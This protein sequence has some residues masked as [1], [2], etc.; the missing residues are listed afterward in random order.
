M[1]TK[2]FRRHLALVGATV[3]TAVGAVAC[4]SDG[5]GDGGS[6]GSVTWYTPMPEEPARRLAEAF[7]RESGIEVKVLRQSAGELLARLKAEAGNPAADVIGLASGDTGPLAEENLIRSYESETAAEID[8]RFVDPDGYWH[9]NEL[10]LIMMGVHA[11]RWEEETGGA[12][13]PQTWDDLLLPELEGEVVMPNPTLSG[14]GYTFVATQIFRHDGDDAAAWTYLDGFDELVGQYTDSG[15][16]PSQL[17]ATGEYLAGVSFAHDLLNVRDAGFPIELVYPSP[18]G[19]VI[20]GN[21]LVD[22]APNPEGGEQFVEWLQGRDA[23]QMIV[24]LVR[25]YPVRDDV[26]LPDGAM[27]LADL[28][29]VDYDPVKAGEMRDDVSAEYADRYGI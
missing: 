16:A 25:S 10:I 4:G 24:D 29:L 6:G 26:D 3:L 1:R 15:G 18:T 21:A 9:A 12:P 2:L 28:D 11:E 7:E 14:T 19:L 27:N 17:V 23:S 5:G 22:D 20:A 13:I 8:D